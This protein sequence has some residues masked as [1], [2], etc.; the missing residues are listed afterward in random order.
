MVFA[1]A[2]KA[3]VSVEIVQR[4]NLLYRNVPFSR[5]VNILSLFASNWFTGVFFHGVCL[6]KKGTKETGNSRD[7]GVTETSIN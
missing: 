1:L 2:W 4:P 5:R 6:R 7:L 3:V